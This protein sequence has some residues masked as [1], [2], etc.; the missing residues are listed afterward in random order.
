MQL[1]FH[2]FPPSSHAEW[3][4]K[5]LISQKL[6]SYRILLS[7]LMRQ[8]LSAD[9]FKSTEYHILFCILNKVRVLWFL[10]GKAHLSDWNQSNHC[11]GHVKEITFIFYWSY[12]PE[13]I[14]MWCWWGLQEPKDNEQMRVMEK[15]KWKELQQ[16][17]DFPFSTWTKLQQALR[18]K[19]I[20]HSKQQLATMFLFRAWSQR[21]WFTKTGV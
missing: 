1:V 16:E 13:Y 19:K 4:L 15:K 7:S 18:A 2:F 20:T 8:P 11:T 9:S 6:H 12:N 10:K 3:A 21:G 14:E 17:S 5:V